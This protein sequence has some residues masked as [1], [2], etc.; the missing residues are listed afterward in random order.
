M[1][2]FYHIGDLVNAVVA[3]FGSYSSKLGYAGED[4]P[5]SYFRSVGAMHQFR[6]QSMFPH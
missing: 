2:G 1:A 6:M 3:D 4:F 5:K